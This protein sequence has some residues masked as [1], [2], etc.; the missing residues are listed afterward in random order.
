MPVPVTFP[1]SFLDP[2]IRANAEYADYNPSFFTIPKSGEAQ[3]F[4][5]TGIPIIPDEI[6]PRVP[7]SQMGGQYE[8]APNANEDV[9]VPSGNVTPTGQASLP[10]GAQKAISEICDQYQRQLGLNPT[11]SAYGNTG[12]AN[13]I[14]SSSPPAYH[15]SLPSS[16]GVSNAGGPS[17]SVIPTSSIFCLEYFTKW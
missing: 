6:G 8:E 3:G 13:L 4:T 12:A 10:L 16:S 1:P 11:P 7:D 5:N 17:P 2:A 14:T 15:W 9:N